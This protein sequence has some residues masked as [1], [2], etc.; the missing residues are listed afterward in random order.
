MESSWDMLWLGDPGPLLKT[1]SPGKSSGG[2]R[3]EE[4]MSLILK[5]KNIIRPWFTLQVILR[6]HVKMRERG[7]N[8]KSSTLE[9]QT[10]ILF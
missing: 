4:L 8:Y 3:K 9:Y 10:Y 7:G 2:P 5:Q 1:R 6:G